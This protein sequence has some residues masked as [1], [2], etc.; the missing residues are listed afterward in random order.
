MNNPAV[1]A[2]AILVAF[3]VAVHFAFIGYLVIGGFV[4]SPRART[5]G[6]HIP[7]DGF[8]ALISLSMLVVARGWYGGPVR[9]VSHHCRTR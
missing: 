9:V 7:P 8:I 6:L 4:A 5:I 2:L 3:T 1:V